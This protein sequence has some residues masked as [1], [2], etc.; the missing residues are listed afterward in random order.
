LLSRALFRSTMPKDSKP[1]LTKLEQ[2][3]GGY[4]TCEL[5]LNE[6]DGSTID[7]AICAET[8][9]NWMS[10]SKNDEDEDF[11]KEQS[12]NCR[13]LLEL[14]VSV[15]L[16]F[17]AQFF[18]FVIM[19]YWVMS[20]V[21]PI[22]N[23]FSAEGMAN[24]TDHI[25]LARESNNPA[26]VP[27]ADQMMCRMNVSYPWTHRLM[28]FVLLAKML[29]KFCDVFWR[30]YKVWI[31]EAQPNHHVEA[32]KEKVINNL[33]GV[34]APYTLE[35]HKPPGATDPKKFLTKD[36]N[37]K[38]LT[39]HI[40]DF[41]DADRLKYVAKGYASGKRVWNCGINVDKEWKHQILILDKFGY[42]RK[43]NSPLEDSYFPIWIIH[44]DVDAEHHIGTFS[45]AWKLFCTAFFLLP[46]VAMTFYIT[47]VGSQLISYT[48]TIN[49][50]IK[51]ALKIKFLNDI[52]EKV[53][54]GYA[55]EDLK[56][57]VDGTLYYAN[58]KGV[59]TKQDHWSSWLSIISKILLCLVG[60]FVLYDVCFAQVNTFRE[61]CT[62]FFVVFHG[63]VI[64]PSAV[65]NAY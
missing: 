37:G 48:G 15:G 60:S 17:T 41:L 57:F 34:P 12:A 2:P 28:M 19:N 50:L 7:A 39:Q 4:T 54:D 51:A 35:M 18:Q 22:G 64:A 26:L 5:K 36:A 46:S 47:Y 32:S 38:L 24:I 21:K 23:A 61:V 43:V 20:L 53:F 49:K 11:A 52:P 44:T 1:K 14:Y 42:M 3:E 59:P 45:I 6:L 56:D 33:H 55:S 58:T 25:Q 27:L 65:L 63:R 10:Q 31:L 30:V 16:H 29:P 9:Y 62:D 8:R 40:W 13:P